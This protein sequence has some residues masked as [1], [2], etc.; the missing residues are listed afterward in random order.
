VNSTDSE[1]P[2]YAVF[3]VPLLP[4]RFEIYILVLKVRFGDLPLRAVRPI[5][6]TGV[7]LPSR[8]CILY[9]FFNKCKCWVF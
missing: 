8:C 5:Y 4:H 1:A 9:I 2:H 6:R 7:R 3:S